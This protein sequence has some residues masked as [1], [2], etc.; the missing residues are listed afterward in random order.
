MLSGALFARLSARIGRCPDTDRQEAFVGAKES[1]TGIIASRMIAQRSG[2]MLFS[3]LRGAA[4]AS[5]AFLTSGTLHAQLP[6]PMSPAA[7]TRQPAFRPATQTYSP[8]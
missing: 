1:G 8:A 4:L 7:Y 3:R 6:Y 2:I 5:L